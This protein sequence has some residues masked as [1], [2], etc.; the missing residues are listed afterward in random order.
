MSPIPTNSLGECPD[1]YPNEFV[2]ILDHMFEDP[3]EFVGIAGGYPN[4][5]RIRWDSRR[6]AIPT[7][8]LG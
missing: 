1:G 4:D 7:N 5:Q 8:S 2:G 6:G 3:N